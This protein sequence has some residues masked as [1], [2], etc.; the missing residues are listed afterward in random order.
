MSTQLQ[1]VAKFAC[2]AEAWHAFT[3]GGLW[4]SGTRLTVIG[5][6]ETPT[7]HLVGVAANAAIAV[8][9]SFYDWRQPTRPAREAA[10]RPTL[11]RAGPS[12]RA[13][14]AARAAADRILLAPDRSHG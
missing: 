4:L 7:W 8:A 11:A 2:G 13:G 6:K 3:H 14:Q 1:E 12:H 9:L 10:G 5:I